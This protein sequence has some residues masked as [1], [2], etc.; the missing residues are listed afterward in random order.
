MAG[1]QLL[2][3]P[4]WFLLISV[5]LIAI[6]MLRSMWAT[7]LDGFSIDEPWH[8]TAGVAY[9]R[10]GE[11]YLNPE[12]PPLVKLVAAL[13]AP[14]GVFHFCEPS[15]LKDK[16]TERDFVQATMH[17]EN[18]ADAIQ[19]R[20]RRVIYMFN[21]LL[22]LF[23]VWTVF[24]TAGGAVAIGALTFILIDPTVAAHWPAVMTDLPVALLSV[25]SVLLCVLVIREWSLLNLVLLAIALGLTLSSKHSGVI[26]FGFVAVVGTAAL[27]WQFL[28]ER[29]TGLRRL[30][31]FAFALVCA[32]IILWAMYG[33]HYR[34][35]SPGHGNFNRSLEAKIE[36]V[37]SATWRFCLGQIAHWHI[38]PRSYVWG[39]ADIVRTG[40]EGRGYS[41][42]AFGR[43]SF[44]ESRPLIFPGYVAVKVPIALTILSL[45]GCALVLRR[46]A[47]GRL[48]ESR[49]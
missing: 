4:R 18:D 14:R 10:T 32:V 45:F 33:F 1:M 20:V 39:F 25:T 47:R 13:A 46:E 16:D 2:A 49:P 36:D 12:H 44:M 17:D 8:I 7:R 48:L 35:S 43:L 19:M 42:L 29:Q 31:A 15:G 38:L 28:R 5:L 9:L 34:E 22:I 21:G 23:F 30:A 41:T 24:R 37:R 40:M 27:L 3:R 11:Y 26:T 6:G